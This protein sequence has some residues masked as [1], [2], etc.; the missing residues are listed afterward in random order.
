[1]G[2]KKYD[3]DTWVEDW[4]RKHVGNGAGKDGNGKEISEMVGELRRVWN[5]REVVDE[6]KAI[7]KERR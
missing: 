6:A 2:N 5:E 7:V 1:M 4:D 3:Q